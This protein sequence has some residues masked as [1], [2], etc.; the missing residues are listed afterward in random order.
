MFLNGLKIKSIIRK[1]KKEV[2]SRSYV[3]SGKPIRRVGILQEEGAPFD[4]KK[5]ASLTK[6][7][8]IKENNVDVFSFILK[9]VK[10]QKEVEGVYSVKSIGWNGILKTTTLKAFVAKDF[11]VLLSYYT[12]DQLPLRLV[13]G[14]SRATFK[15]G[16]IREEQGLHDLV[17]T[18]AIDEESLFVSE[19]EKY[20]R[21]LKIL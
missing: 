20:L 19:L 21:I 14:L 3:P 10:D 7:L 17:I 5:I 9:P 4:I 2:A 18:T 13:S 1:L 8:G 11:D 16:L 15:V 6:A 12:E